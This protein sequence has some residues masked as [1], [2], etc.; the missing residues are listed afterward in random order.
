MSRFFILLGYFEL[1]LYLQL[2]GKITYYLNHQYVYLALLSM[3]LSLFLLIIQLITWMKELGSVSLKQPRLKFLSLIML[4]LPLVIGF[5]LPTT[6]LNSRTVK[7]KGY[8]FPTALTN[9]KENDGIEQ[10]YLK[11]D[12]SLY[13]TAKS[14]QKEMLKT[15]QKYDKA[16]PIIVT[17]QNYMEIM[18]LIYLFP[19]SFLDRQLT[20]TGFVYNHPTLKHHIYLFRFGIIHCVADSGVYG[21]LTKGHEKA[22]AD[23]TWLEISGRIQLEYQKDFQ[24]LLPLVQVEQVKEIKQPQNP[25]VYRTF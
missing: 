17:D 14:Y 4:T 5:L 21:L 13:F 22:Y 18:E 12:T 2:S 15:L 19:K 25:Y 16:N 1:V 7:T 3:L 6:S 9:S 10:Q 20:F 23:N 8:Y 11:P 24:Q